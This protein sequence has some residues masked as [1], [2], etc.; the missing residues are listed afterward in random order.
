MKHFITSLSLLLL[1]GTTVVTA[2]NMERVKAYG[3]KGQVTRNLSA[4]SR[5][6]DVTVL[7]KKKVADKV[8]VRT[9]R[10]KSGRIYKDIERGG[11]VKGGLQPRSER[12]RFEPSK[13]ASFYEGFEGYTGEL[14][15][16]PEGWT[17]ITT[18][19]NIPTKEMME[20]NIDNSWHGDV[21]GD[22][23][24]TDITTDGQY[25]CYIHF[26]YDAQYTDDDGNEVNIPKADQDEW[27]ITPEFT[28]KENQSLFFLTQVDFGMIFGFDWS[29]GT[30]VR[31]KLVSNLIVKI[32]Q[33]GGQTWTDVWQAK[34]IA[35]AMTDKEIYDA[36]SVMKY[37]TVSVP[38]TEY[39]GK[40]IKVAFEYINNV[41]SGENGNSAAID[42]VL[43]DAPQAGAG[44]ELPK[45]VMF[46]GFDREGYSFNGSMAIIPPYRDITWESGNN[47]YTDNTSWSF[48]DPAT[49]GMTDVRE[50][51]NVTLQNA[52]TGE[53][54]YPYPVIKASNAFSEDTYQF[55]QGDQTQGG[56]VYAGKFPKIQ[57]ENGLNK[58]PF[59]NLDY[60]HKELILHQFSYGKYV[61]GTSD[62]DSWGEYQCTGFGNF[63]P[64]CGTPFTLNGVY[65]GLGV[66]DMD[67]DAEI[68]VEVYT[69]DSYGYLSATPIAT[70]RL[71]GAQIKAAKQDTYFWY[72]YFPLVDSNNE[73]LSYTT[74]EDLIVFVKG[75]AYNEKVR[76]FA[77][78]GQY[79]NNAPSR[80]Y[81]F[82]WF[83][84]DPWEFEQDAS[85]VLQD[86]SNALCI[87]LDGCYN[88]LH[89]DEAEA[90]IPAT[91]LS[92]EITVEAGCDP[93]EWTV[94]EVSGN[95]SLA[96]A[97]TLD[98]L[99]LSA[100]DNG[101]GRYTLTAQA[102]A[103]QAARSINVTL[104]D[105]AG[106]ELP[107]LIRQLT[108]DSGVSDILTAAVKVSALA[109]NI[110]VSGAPA[111][112]EVTLYT[113]NGSVIARAAADAEGNARFSSMMKGIYLVKVGNRVF[114]VM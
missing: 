99:T 96:S 108:T 20:R 114:K 55:G 60:I 76:E 41:E 34:D 8:Y 80:N 85:Q 45:G 6:G 7:N 13:D 23:Y 113:A 92:K 9:V 87:T 105:P 24:W 51:N 68:T 83:K 21:T 12:P 33:D 79:T 18:P 61:F 94:K 107:L 106:N 69:R 40:S 91:A 56:V 5:S 49:E 71:T 109:G 52:C 50:G 22:G 77:C 66:V 15:W 25:E 4:L 14:G 44:Y 74:I 43:V 101:E 36:M 70:S 35:E 31:S 32:S 104:C 95:N 28:V 67:D 16:L 46:S 42:G 48:Y 90:V 29:T 82:L 2:Q 3:K 89:T 62:P 54:V 39:Y 73:P 47:A 37:R 19:G 38:L 88:F 103:T 93:E 86:F 1:A 17:E 72:P 102:P 81:A 110:Y 64:S 111:G 65:V 53:E 27:L 58:V 11:V 75:Y 57:T 78:Y 100:R 112:Q 10:D 84:G 98:W 59:M 97:V 63:F 26:G 30:P